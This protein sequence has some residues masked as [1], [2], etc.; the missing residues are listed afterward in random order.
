MNGV[1][2][3]HSPGVNVIIILD[4]KFGDFLENQYYI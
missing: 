3:A 1:I 2:H 4:E